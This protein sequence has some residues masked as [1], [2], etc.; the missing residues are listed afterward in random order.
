[1]TTGIIWC[2]KMLDVKGDSITILKPDDN[3]LYSTSKLI[4]A[5]QAIK[6]G[7]KFSLFCC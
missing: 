4:K 2:F 6:N 3:A 5:E 1:M 7:M